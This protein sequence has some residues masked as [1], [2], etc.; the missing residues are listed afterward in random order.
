MMNMMHATT[1]DGRRSWAVA[2]IWN[3]CGIVLYCAAPNF[4]FSP[5]FLAYISLV[6]G[7]HGI[8]EEAMVW[9]AHGSRDTFVW[10]F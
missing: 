5:A 8:F 10:I 1:G 9:R 3:F 4:H 7:N 2:G 6:Q